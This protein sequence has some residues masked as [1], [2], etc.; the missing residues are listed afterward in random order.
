MRQCAPVA[1]FAYAR[2]DHLRQTV[3]ALAANELASV[4]EVYL[5]S[6]AAR[7]EKDAQ[8]VSEV[9]QY[10]K[11]IT[12][13]AAVHLIERQHNFGLADSII[14]G[15]TTLM[16]RYGRAIVVEDDIVSSPYFLTYMNDALDRYAEN[17]RVMHVAA[18]MPDIPVDGLPETF[19]MRQSSCWGWAS[20]A[21]AWNYFVRQGQPYISKFSANDIRRFNLDGAYD[22]WQQLLAN[23]AGKLK[24]WAVY[25]YATVFAHGG[26]CLHPRE[27]LVY[28][29]GFD[30]SGE[31]CGNSD[32]VKVCLAQRPVNEFPAEPEL[33]QEHKLA[34][35]RY[36][37]YLT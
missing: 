12:G 36:Q 35:R 18:Y 19:F 28:N 27:S 2:P 10:A 9:R 14:D 17:E 15:V 21:R 7:S 30:G 25:W 16:N 22:Y 23:E 29:I 26:L 37:K 8:I 1:L 6:D 20:W 4:T 34:M 11:S 13:F 32:S 33:F 24:T 31:N 5:F 3:E